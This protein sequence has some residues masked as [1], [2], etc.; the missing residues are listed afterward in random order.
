[1][2]AF[3]SFRADPRNEIAAAIKTLLSTKTLAG[4]TVGLDAI[5][6]FE[7]F[8]S[9][10]S[11]GLDHLIEIYTLLAKDLAYAVKRFHGDDL[12]GRNQNALV[13]LRDGDESPFFRPSL[14]RT[15]AGKVT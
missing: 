1:M 9:N 7:Q 14:R 15:S 11:S 3:K 8:A 12:L 5:L 6:L 13:R 4:G 10:V 2:P